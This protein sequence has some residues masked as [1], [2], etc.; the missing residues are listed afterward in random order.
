M[1]A[2]RALDRISRLL[3]LIPYLSMKE[4]RLEELSRRLQVDE[5]QLR[6]DLEIAFLC[7][8][9]GYTPDLLIDLT[10]DESYI[11]VSNPQSLNAPRRI[12]DLERATLLLGLSLLE[13]R[14]FDVAKVSSTV[15]NLRAKLNVGSSEDR[16][17]D[18]IHGESEERTPLIENAIAMEERLT[19]SY[20]D[21]TGRITR[22]RDVS[23]WRLIL[24]RGQVILRGFDHE[25]DGVR[26]FLV[27]RVTDL[28][29]REGVYQAER[30]WKESE[31]QRAT[32]VLSSTPM[33]WRRRNI[34]LID[35]I[36]ERDGNFEVRI[37]FWRRESVLFSLLP[38][39]DH[40]VGFTADDWTAEDLRHELLRHFRGR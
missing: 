37:H 7:G 26:E 6:R 15:Q 12:S 23:P 29:T 19:F 8:L 38:I 11:A 35:E 2:D 1:P 14:Y 24:R 22:N 25:R 9:P 21:L 3:D 32:I 31:P 18:E 20:M 10:F 4:I 27:Y 40:L 5:A 17:L 30:E 33:W 34:N 13:V 28:D 36:S 16:S 39:V